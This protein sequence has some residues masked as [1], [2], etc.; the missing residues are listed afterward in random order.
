[1]LRRS[2]PR[3]LGFPTACCRSMAA[4]VMSSLTAP[5][6]LCYNHAYARQLLAEFIWAE[7]FMIVAPLEKICRTLRHDPDRSAVLHSFLSDERHHLESFFRI[8]DLATA[9]DRPAAKAVL[10]PPRLLR[11]LVAMAARFPV[12]VSFWAAAT[13]AF[14]QYTI[15]LGQSFHRDE[16]VDPLFR[17]IFVAHARDEARHCRLDTLIE[18]LAPRGRRSAVERRQQ[19]AAIDLR[20]RLPVGGL[21]ARWP[22]ARPRAP[23]SGD[24]EQGPG[25]ARRGKSFAALHS[26]AGDF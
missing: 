6:R 21:G 24:F 23:S 20:R 3:G 18:G 10:R 5:Q 19:P 7:S 13:E 12:K 4:G 16:D 1:M 9:A 11:A 26:L 14:E 22:P 15:K 17:E 25:L 8:Q 2:T